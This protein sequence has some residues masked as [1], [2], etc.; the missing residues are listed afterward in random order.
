MLG[1]NFS[2]EEIHEMIDA[3]DSSGD[4]KIYFEEFVRIMLS[5]E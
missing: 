2:L 3:A 4:H 1:C 5:N